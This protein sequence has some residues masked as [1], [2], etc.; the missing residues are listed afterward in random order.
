MKMIQHDDGKV[1]L[2]VHEAIV[3]EQWNRDRL[4]L[5]RFMAARGVKLL[6]ANED[7]A[8]DDTPCHWWL[9]ANDGPSL[10]RAVWEAVSAGLLDR[11]ALEAV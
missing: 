1:A 8:D 4:F 3:T 6:D 10:T 5:D 9:Y 2:D 7:G 11:T